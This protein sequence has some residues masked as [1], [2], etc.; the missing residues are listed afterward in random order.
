MKDSSVLFH[1]V[2]IVATVA[3]VCLWALFTRFGDLAADPA[4][5]LSQSAGVLFDP[6]SHSGNARS[7]I[8]F[9]D[10]HP[11]QW[12]TYI[13]SPLYVLLQVVWF[14]VWGISVATMHA[15]GA[16]W[17]I[18]TLILCWLTFRQFGAVAGTLA[19]TLLTG[20]YLF[21]QLGRLALLENCAIFFSFV[22]LY[23]LTKK[24][25]PY[26][27]FFC[28]FFAFLVFV[29][30]GIIFYAV[31]AVGAG[32][33][34]S[35]VQRYLNDRKWKSSLLLFGWYILGTV[36]A[37][38]PWLF[39]FRIP[40]DAEISWL[41]PV[42]WR[43]V[44]PGG[45]ENALNYLIDD[46]LFTRIAPH[47][48]ASVVMLLTIGFTLYRLMT[49]WRKTKPLAVTLLFYFF[50]GAL[51]VGLLRYKPTR[52]AE[53]LIPP[54]LGLCAIGLAD[55]WKSGSLRAT[56]QRSWAADICG[57]FTLT[58][59]FRMQLYLF[60][61]ARRVFGIF[62]FGFLPGQW[63]S[64]LACFLVAVLF[65]IAIRVL[66]ILL[67]KQ[68]VQIPDAFRYSL[69]LL[70]VG[71][72]L[73]AN[74]SQ[75]LYWWQGREHSIRDASRQLQDKS[76]MVIGG[77]SVHALVMETGHRAVRVEH[78]GWHN[79]S[80][81]NR[82]FSDLEL[83]HFLLTD[84]N[85][86]RA[87]YFTRYPREMK[88]LQKIA[89]FPM[90]GHKFHLYKIPEGIE[91]SPPKKPRIKKRKKGQGRKKKAGLAAHENA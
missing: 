30:K 4:L 72:F 52:F 81:Q 91:L 37:F 49:D 25:T 82:I 2:A 70:F 47:D 63:D 21:S 77:L 61:V 33:L 29:T 62:E 13:Y 76:H 15:Y 26:R 60:S 39:L 73:Y 67:V 54:M 12:N 69:V 16:T 23:F 45:W 7:Y 80:G 40:N 22:S 31:P 89:V 43:S 17:S 32:I 10:L 11:D 19:L 44:T 90:C 79:S 53:P 50:F 55:F 56:F 46:R 65:W 84:Y 20:H 88:Q 35:L 42:W 87:E 66:L 68:E 51:F 71:H 1:R 74:V 59:I 5:N 6:F 18:L 24:L 57:V 58:L 3:I 75:T 8:L 27:A 86:Q 78:G 14:K 9:G 28:G 41:G 36:S 64:L 38:V 34:V 48:F 85:R 83:T